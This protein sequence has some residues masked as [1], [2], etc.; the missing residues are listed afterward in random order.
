[1]ELPLPGHGAGFV[2]ERP[3]GTVG[4]D[5]VR[6]EQLAADRVE[7]LAALDKVIDDSCRPSLPCCAG[8]MKALNGWTGPRPRD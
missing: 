4:G 1:M 5:G 3:G 6:E 7:K 8:S 2:D